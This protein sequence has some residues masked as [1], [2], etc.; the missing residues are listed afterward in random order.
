MKPIERTLYSYLEEFAAEMPDK[1]LYADEDKSFTAK[2]TYG[3]VNELANRLYRLG[4][5]AESE[6]VIRATRS[7]EATLLYFALQ[8]IGALTVLADAHGNTAEY[9][10]GS[11]V[12]LSP[13]CIITND[14]DADVSARGNWK[15]YFSGGVEQFEITL[16]EEEKL[17]FSPCGDVHKPAVLLFTSGTTGS[18]KGVVLSQYNTVNHLRNIDNGDY[19]QT[20]VSVNNLPVYHVFGLA[21]VM[22]ALVRRYFVFFPKKV[23]IEYVA[24]CIKK[25][26][27]TR[28]DGVPSYALALSRYAAE[29]G[30]KLPTLRVAET[31]GAP[32]TKEQYRFIEKTLNLKIIP[33][34]GMSELIAISCGEISDGESDRWGS[35]GKIL[36]MNVCRILGADGKDMPV[37]CTGEICV[38]GP[39]KFLGYYGESPYVS[40]GLLHTGDLGYINGNGFLHVTGR[41]KDIIIRNGNNLSV[42]GIERKILSLPQVK[43]VC[44]VGIEHDKYGEVPC[45]MIV[46]EKEAHLSDVLNS[47]EM[48]AKVLYV[49]KIPLTPSGKPDKQAVREILKKL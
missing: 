17:C 3:K 5:R 18:S 33:V 38:E 32:C 24:E 19:R 37:N 14:V 39:A 20:D 40:G 6:V 30:I 13:D 45:A 16:K 2:Q 8:A 1:L 49:E 41:I 47:I 29:K 9:I 28:L 22:M 36:P 25:Y 34:Y 42:F 21:L 15:I 48:P 23:D 27:A 7:I 31:G 11:G 26:G 4:I 43:D 10:K 12:N 35:V 46:S 44:V